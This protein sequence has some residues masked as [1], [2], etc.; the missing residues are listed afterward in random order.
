MANEDRFLTWQGRAFWG[1]TAVFSHCGWLSIPSAIFGVECESVLCKERWASKL[2]GYN[3]AST[4]T[5]MLWQKVFICT[6]SAAL[7]RLRKR[8][9]TY[10][11]ATWNEYH[12]STLDL[13]FLARSRTF[14]P[15][16]PCIN[17]RYDTRQDII[18]HMCWLSNMAEAMCMAM[19]I[20]VI[21]RAPSN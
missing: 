21:A 9:K 4:R 17:K 16:Y 11:H 2:L 18:Q 3:M 7:L 6:G 12:H 19:W 8:R 5:L 15:R 14:Y 1:G 13:Q 10:P 20:I